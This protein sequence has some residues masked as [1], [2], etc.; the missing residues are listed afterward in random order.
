M[1]IPLNLNLR[2][3]KVDHVRNADVV[4]AG[5]RYVFP[6]DVASPATR[7]RPAE[8]GFSLWS[9][10]D[11][12]LPKPIERQLP[13]LFSVGGTDVPIP[14]RPLQSRGNRTNGP[15][16]LVCCIC[17]DDIEHTPLTCPRCSM[18][19]H[20]N[21]LCKWFGTRAQVE[22][23]D[24]PGVGRGALTQA[25]ACPPPG[26]TERTASHT[27]RAPLTRSPPGC[28]TQART[29]RRTRR[30]CCR[31]RARPAPTAA[32]LWTGMRSRS[33][34]GARPRAGAPRCSAHSWASSRLAPRMCRPR[35]IE[36][37]AGSSRTRLSLSND[38]CRDEAACL[39]LQHSRSDEE[40][41]R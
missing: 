31:P 13:G 19:A 33:T 35:W 11:A 36:P 2:R 34:I 24:T 32:R 20:P 3:T 28:G 27:S 26:Q 17:L 38:E 7:V 23:G 12:M 21:C 37:R 14:M 39:G 4:R 6:S 16:P 8:S 41:L 5:S 18:S 40:C 1:P 30:D 25:R 10:A 9:P 15:E 22:E 29:P